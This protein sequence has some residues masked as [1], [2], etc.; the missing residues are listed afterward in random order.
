MPIPNK[1]IAKAVK[2]AFINGT[3]EPQS[4]LVKLAHLNTD[5]G[6]KAYIVQLTKA[7][8]EK[9][10]MQTRRNRHYGAKKG[11]HKPTAKP[12]AMK[13]HEES[14]S[15]AKGIK[16]FTGFHGDGDLTAFEHSIGFIPESIASLELQL[17]D[18]HDRIFDLKQE[19]AR[20]HVI[21]TYLEGRIK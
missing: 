11:K 3:H 7:L 16:A 15:V 5:S 6:R 4:M 13:K 21:I 18:A 14:H 17:E 2:E 8:R 12:K 19:V 20:L 10:G 1:G 9:N